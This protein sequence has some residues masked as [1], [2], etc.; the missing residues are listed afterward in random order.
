MNQNLYITKSGKLSRKDNTL[1]FKNQ[2]IKKVIPIEGV[3]TI[4]LFGETSLNTK[5]LNFLSQKQ[6]ILHTF[7]YYGFYSGS[8]VPKDAYVSGKLLVS[9]VAHYT[10]LQKRLTIARKFVLGIANSLLYI[11][12]HYQKHGAKIKKYTNQ[13]RTRIDN[14]R[15][16]TD[17]KQL[18]SVEGGIWDNFYTTFK[19]ILPKNFQM[20][21]RKIRPP[22]NPINA[23][24]SFANSLLYTQVLSQIYQTQ[25]NPTI[26][27]LHEPSER[28]FSLSLDLAEI[29]KAEM[30]FRL[31]FKLINKNMIKLE[32]FDKKKNFCLLNNKGRIKFLEE[33]D[34][35]LNKTYKHPKL[36]RKVS[37]KKLFKL[38]C[39][40]LIKHLLGEK[41]YRSYNMDVKF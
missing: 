6:I 16:T 12:K 30:T 15:E 28:R 39:Y 20:N 24:I 32:D 41:E 26:S 25:L 35:R 4:Y 19:K 17:I 18:L 23:L 1:L 11:L 13:I 22:D 3:K 10:D 40:K 37:N 2:K 14:I 9:Q 38:E 5:L 29:F 33:F 36:K 7:N 21:T 31:I 27:Y 8:Y 34:K